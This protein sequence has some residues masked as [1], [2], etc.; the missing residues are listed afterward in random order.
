MYTSLSSGLHVSVYGRLC[1]FTGLRA[2]T[3]PIIVQLWMPAGDLFLNQAYRHYLQCTRKLRLVCS[4]P[5]AHSHARAPMNLHP[6]HKSPRYCLCCG[7]SA[8]KPCL[9]F[10]LS[11]M[12]WCFLADSQPQSAR[13]SLGHTIACYTV[14][15]VLCAKSLKRGTA[16]A[17]FRHGFPAES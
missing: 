2:G 11:L 10:E 3:R 13:C 14:P 9:Q 6:T 1:M 8:C 17:C 4:T 5:G 7:S 16:M 15:M 12:S